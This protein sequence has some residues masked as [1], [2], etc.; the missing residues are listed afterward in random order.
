MSF[1]AK[2]KIR[3]WQILALFLSNL[4]WVEE[5]LLSGDKFEHDTEFFN[6]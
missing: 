6:H 4:C 3:P 2:E 1:S 5:F